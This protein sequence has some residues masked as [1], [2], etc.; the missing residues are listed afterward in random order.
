MQRS[1][2]SCTGW[3]RRACRERGWGVRAREE[4]IAEILDWLRAGKSSL[5]L[6][7]LEYDPLAPVREDR[8]N[9]I[10]IHCTRD[11]TVKNSNRLPH[12]FPRIQ[13]ATVIFE[14]WLKAEADHVAF[15]EAFLRLMLAGKFS[16]PTTTINMTEKVG[17]FD[18]GVPGAKVLQ[19]HT[20]LMYTDAGL[21]QQDQ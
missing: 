1:R 19:I 18:G 16:C 12:S 8:L 15:Y 2:K 20:E 7:R 6:K 9:A 11:R 5:Q 3:I 14:C 17:P 10:H 4:A 21:V 13:A